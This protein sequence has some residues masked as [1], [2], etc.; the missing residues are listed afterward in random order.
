[1]SAPHLPPAALGRALAALD[2]GLPYKDALEALLLELEPAGADWLMQQLRESRGA[3]AP[4][5]SSGPGRALFIGDPL[6]GTPVALGRLG[7]ETTVLGRDPARLAFAAHRA[8][9]L[10]P[11]PSHFVLAG[12]GGP[13]A[14]LPFR[15]G[16]F[17][18]VVQDG[19][20]PGPA[21][22][23]GHDLAECERVARGELVLVADNRFGYKRSTGA[24]GAFHVLRPLEYARAALAPERGRRGLGGYRR[25]L[26]AAGL[27]RTEAYALYPHSG[28]FVH[29]VA[30]DRP[31]PR[32][33]VGPKERRNHLKVAGLHLGLFPVLTPSFALF[34]TRAAGA[35]ARRIDRILAAL[36]ERL[37]EPAPEVDQLVATRGNTA[38]FLTRRPGPEGADEQRD[39]RG[40]WCLHLPLSPSQRALAERHVASLRRLR[41]EYPAVPVPEPLFEG[42]LEGA[43]LTCERRLAGRTAPELSDDPAV[44]RRLLADAARLTSALTLGPPRQLDEAGFEALLGRKLALVLRH[45]AVPSTLAR[46]RALGDRARE[47]LLGRSFPRVLYHADLRGKHVQIDAAGR[48]LGILDW[49]T[50]ED[51]GLPYADLLHLAIHER[52]QT[53][54]LTAGAAWRAVCDRRARLPR[55]AEA[56]D[57]YAAALGLEEGYVRLIEDLYPV[58]VGAMAERNWD[59]SRPRWV[60]EQFAF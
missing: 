50:L 17:E 1:V 3:W 43:Y 19:G 41:A 4:L 12:D 5:A 46:T 44:G 6:S 30:L 22:G 52:K 56:L 48:V 57:S 9:A 53:E 36:G 29:V 24:H 11:T 28:Q 34:A 23:W 45:A 26:A 20:L 18:L 7:F 35:A 14:G 51:P 58:L 10:V 55:E 21:T 33:P 13:R 15:D 25:A 54:T 16:S 8:R 2:G 42:V 27:P 40:R 49:S 32:L 38:V 37:E 60:H 31:R 47:E 39:P 59:Y